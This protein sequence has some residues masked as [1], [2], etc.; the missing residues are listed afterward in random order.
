MTVTN[1]PI[2]R[3]LHDV[4]G[5]YDKSL[6]MFQMNGRI[7]RIFYIFMKFCVREICRSFLIGQWL[8]RCANLERKIHDRGHTKA[9]CGFGWSYCL[10]KKTKC[11][12]IVRFYF[13]NFCQIYRSNYV[14]LSRHIVYLLIELKN[15]VKNFAQN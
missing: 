2:N 8:S 6:H 5:W 1:N 13:L 4:W 15:W 7:R 10:K 12:K 9:A 11:G 3:R 14:N